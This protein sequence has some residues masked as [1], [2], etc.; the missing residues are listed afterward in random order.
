MLGLLPGPYWSWSIWSGWQITDT[1]SSSWPVYLERFCPHVEVILSYNISWYNIFIKIF[2]CYSHCG[3]CQD[4]LNI[5]TKHE[6]KFWFYLC[7]FI[8]LFIL[9]FFYYILMFECLINNEI[10]KVF[11]MGVCWSLRWCERGRCLSLMTVRLS[12]QVSCLNL[13]TSRAVW[14]FFGPCVWLCKCFMLHVLPDVTFLILL[15]PRNLWAQQTTFNTFNMDEQRGEQLGLPIPTF[16]DFFSYFSNVLIVIFKNKILKTGWGWKVKCMM[17][18]PAVCDSVSNTADSITKRKNAFICWDDQKWRW[19][20]WLQGEGFS[21][22]IYLIY[23]HSEEKQVLITRLKDSKEE[24]QKWVWTTKT[25]TH[26]IWPSVISTEKNL[27][28]TDEV[29]PIKSDL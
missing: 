18:R 13:G 28:V 23:C 17:D 27:S 16:P 7:G 3:S 19:V 1:H 20:N 25:A 5:C 14:N 4:F 2:F 24:S 12:A 26:S 10:F 9:L 15:S 22:Q 29:S 8:Y 11:H 6:Q 21:F